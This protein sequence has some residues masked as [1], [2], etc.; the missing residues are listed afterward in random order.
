MSST[1]NGVEM[2]N[3]VQTAILQGVTAIGTL[4]CAGAAVLLTLAVLAAGIL[5][6]AR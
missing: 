6:P 5:R 4:G 1:I 2:L 3:Q